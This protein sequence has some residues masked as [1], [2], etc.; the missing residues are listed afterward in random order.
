MLTDFMVQKI[1]SVSWRND[2]GEGKA[3]IIKWFD[4]FFELHSVN[5][6]RFLTLFLSKTTHLCQWL[7]LAW[8]FVQVWTF[9]CLTNVPLGM[10]GGITQ[11]LINASF[12]L[13]VTGIW[14]PLQH[15]QCID[16]D[17]GEV[18][19]RQW[20]LDEKVSCKMYDFVITLHLK[21]VKI[22][23]QKLEILLLSGLNRDIRY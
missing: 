18:G 13:D 3:I 17:C 10:K 1:Y 15:L 12:C 20:K 21:T 16:K 6:C 11:V 8:H 5:A 4:K 19:L 7:L 14:L 9:S 2:L 22:R 23:R